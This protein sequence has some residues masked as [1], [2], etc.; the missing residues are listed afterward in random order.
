MAFAPPF[1]R[2]SLIIVGWFV[3]L[4]TAVPVKAAADPIEFGTVRPGSDRVNGLKN[5][6]QLLKLR[7][8]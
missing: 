3:V 6:E 2:V 1:N 4:S 7:L 8:F 5:K